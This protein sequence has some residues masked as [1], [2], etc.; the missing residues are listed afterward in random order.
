MM[1]H[2]VLVYDES[3]QPLDLSGINS[4]SKRLADVDVTEMAQTMAVNSMAPFIL[5]SRLKLLLSP[6]KQDQAPLYY[7]HIVNVTAL[8]GKFNV[9]KKSGGHPHTN[10]SKAALNMLTLTASRSYAAEGILMNAADTGWVTDMAP[11]GLGAQ[12]RIHETF[13]GPPL[14]DLDGASRVLDP[15]FVHINSGGVDTS[16]GHFWKDYMKSSW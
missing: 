10:M 3:G 1:R 6:P 14:D 13:V 4:W 16:N 5:C 7:N 2:D 12:S 8:E 15:V 11:K 9:G